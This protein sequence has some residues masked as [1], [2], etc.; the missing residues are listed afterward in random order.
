[1]F[2]DTKTWKCKNEPTLR[3][4]ERSKFLLGGIRIPLSDI[5]LWK[6]PL[7]KG[8]IICQ[9][10]K[11]RKYLYYIMVLIPW[12]FAQVDCCIQWGNKHFY[13]LIGKVS[14]LRA[15]CH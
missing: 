4:A 8:D 2:Y 11:N 14:R 7:D 9:K 13:M 12:L 10:G 1:M 6:R 5:A 15:M 3:S